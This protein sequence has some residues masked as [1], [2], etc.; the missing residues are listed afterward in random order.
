MDHLSI[1]YVDES[2]KLIFSHDFSQTYPC[3]VDISLLK[4]TFRMIC[5]NP[6][7]HVVA[8]LVH[9]LLFNL[10]KNNH[11]KLVWELGHRTHYFID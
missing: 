1:S 4:K 7:R 10:Q 3:S 2:A 9:H 6:V 8:L 11:E 5:S